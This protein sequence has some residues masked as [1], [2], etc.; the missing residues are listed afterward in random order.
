[1]KDID[2]LF[3]IFIALIV[4][5]FINFRINELAQVLQ[6]DKCGTPIIREKK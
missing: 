4:I 3:M 6:K 2:R 1:M 5:I